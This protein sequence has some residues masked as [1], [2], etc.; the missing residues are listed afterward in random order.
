MSLLYIGPAK[1]SYKYCTYNILSWMNMYIHITHICT[2]CVCTCTLATR[3]D[4][5][6][7]WATSYIL[8]D[9]KWFIYKWNHIFAIIQT[10]KEYIRTTHILSI[11][12]PKCYPINNIKPSTKTTIKSSTYTVNN[13]H[14]NSIFDTFDNFINTAAITRTN[15]IYSL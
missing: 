1:C 15:F 10:I 11:I 12:K 9:Y 7:H 6:N 3:N 4:Y 8:W 13:P 2:G 14:I 5:F